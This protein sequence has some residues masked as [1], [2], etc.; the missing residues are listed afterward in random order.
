MLEIDLSQPLWMLLAFVGLGCSAQSAY[1]WT[2]AQLPR[3]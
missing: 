1:H 3:C 2:R